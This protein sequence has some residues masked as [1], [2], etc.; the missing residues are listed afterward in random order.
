MDDD[1]YEPYSEEVKVRLPKSFLRLYE[2]S[3]YLH[4]WYLTGLYLANTGAFLQTYSMRG[5]STLQLTFTTSGHEKGI[6]LIYKNLYCFQVDFE[7]SGGA[8]I[9]SPTGF[10]RCLTSRFSI[11]KDN[12][13]CHELEFEDGTMRIV[14]EGTNYRRVVN[15]YWD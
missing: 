6:L 2:K 5:K 7:D 12:R 4:D 10:G 15:N 9:L 3:H 14:C 1:C 13:I 11:G 8:S